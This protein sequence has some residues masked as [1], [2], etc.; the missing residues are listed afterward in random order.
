MD[1]QRI[2]PEKRKS[3]VCGDNSKIERLTSFKPQFSLEAGLTK[4]VE[5]FSEKVI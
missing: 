1:P 3:L 2:R 4:T 5:W